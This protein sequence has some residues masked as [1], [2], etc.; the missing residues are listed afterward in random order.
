[1]NGQRSGAFDPVDHVVRRL[2][3]QRLRWVDLGEGRRVQVLLLRETEM[4]RLR[5]DPLVEI[6]IDQA[7]D[8]DGFTEAAIFGAHDGASDKVPFRAD[9][10]DAIARD[11]VDFV[12]RVGEELIQH[13]TQVMEQRAAAKKA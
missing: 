3:E 13:A 10:W 6:V 11:S 12:N 4:P 2:R 8:W 5:R 1:M 7:V 9:L